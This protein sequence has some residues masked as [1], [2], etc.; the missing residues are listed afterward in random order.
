MHVS[1]DKSFQV[2]CFF[3]FTRNSSKTKD[4]V[5]E[6][7]SCFNSSSTNYLAICFQCFCCCYFNFLFLTQFLL[8]VL[9]VLSDA[10][11]CCFYS[12]PITASNILSDKLTTTKVMARFCLF[13]CLIII[14]NNKQKKRSREKQKMDPFCLGRLWWVHLGTDDCQN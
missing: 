13:I 2:L 9:L 14:I 11:F 6:T 8:L 1:V 3:F 12:N 5:G 10:V 7:S 4:I